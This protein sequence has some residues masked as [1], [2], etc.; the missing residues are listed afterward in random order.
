M[1]GGL[2]H[3]S[4]AVENVVT[5]HEGRQGRA[6]GDGDVFAVHEK[7]ERGGRPEDQ[8]RGDDGASHCSGVTSTFGVL[9][10]AEKGFATVSKADF[11][12]VQIQLAAAAHTLLV[13]GGCY[14]GP[15]GAALGD[16]HD[17]IHDNV[18]DDLEA[19]QLA[20]HCIGGRNGFA[21]DQLDGGSIFENKLGRLGLNIL[22]ATCGLGCKDRHRG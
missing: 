12:D 9:D 6:L 19:D 3:E 14:G 17:A 16:D 20:Y 1:L 5:L 7:K 4:C 13:L 21:E 8:A 15:G 2:F 11:V 22:L 10:G 18:F